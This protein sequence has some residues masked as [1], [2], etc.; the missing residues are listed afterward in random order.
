MVAI[1]GLCPPH[2]MNSP[3][4]TEHAHTN[5]SRRSVGVTLHRKHRSLCYNTNARCVPDGSAPL[6]NKCSWIRILITVRYGTQPHER[7]IATALR[8]SV[9]RLPSEGRSS[10]QSTPAASYVG[11][12]KDK[13]GRFGSSSPSSW[14]TNPDHPHLRAAVTSKTSSNTDATYKSSRRPHRRL[15]FARSPLHSYMSRQSVNA[16]A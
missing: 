2:R 15:L 11:G 9:F 14:D 13:A 4:T 5:L 6:S 10:Q 1:D 16:D 12:C 3:H 8:T 7:Q